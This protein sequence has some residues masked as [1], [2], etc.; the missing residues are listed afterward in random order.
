MLT[1]NPFAEVPAIL[2]LLIDCWWELEG[3]RIIGDTSREDGRLDAR[4]LQSCMLA[5]AGKPDDW[6]LCR[7]EGSEQAASDAPR[8]EA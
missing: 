5:M 2:T 4:A 3:Q 6:E 8:D 7:L 1:V